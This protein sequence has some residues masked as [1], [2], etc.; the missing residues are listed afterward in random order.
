MQAGHGDGR[1]VQSLPDQAGGGGGPVNAPSIQYKIEVST[2]GT[3]ELYL[4]W[5]NNDFGGGI[6]SDSIFVDIVELKDGNGGTI[7]DHYEMVRNSTTF[8]WDGGGGFEKNTAAAADKAMTWDFAQ[9]TYTL[10]ISQR[11]DGSAVD[12]WLLQLQSLPAPTGAGP[13]ALR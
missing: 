10:R 5:A 8:A 6:K 9:G 12:A 4:R 2:G 1:Y 7:A 11:E 3:Y 13:R